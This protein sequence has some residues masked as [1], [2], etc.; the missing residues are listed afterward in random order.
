MLRLLEAGQQYTGRP[1]GIVP[2]NFSLTRDAAIILDH[3]APS[4]KAKGHFLSRLL[5]EY[6]T[7]QTEREKWLQ[8]VTAMLREEDKDT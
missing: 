3:L 7:Q 1:T 4:R 2:V 8:K 5:C 6:V